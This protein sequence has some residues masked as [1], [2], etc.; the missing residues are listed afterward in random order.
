MGTTAVLNSDAAVANFLTENVTYVKVV[1]PTKSD[2]DQVAKVYPESEELDAKIESGDLKEVARQ[3][4]KFYN[5]QTIDGVE[6]LVPN[7]KEQLN[8]LRKALTQKQQNKAR[9]QVLAKDFEPRAETIDLR[10]ACNEESQTRGASEQEK[11]I[12][13]LAGMDE[14]VIN[15]IL[16]MAAKIRAE[17]SGA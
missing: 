1:D 13:S 9:T 17:Q 15:Q 4:F 12:K 6:E 3:S 7:V 14:A 11:M 2:A 10:D 16:A 5:V 8:L